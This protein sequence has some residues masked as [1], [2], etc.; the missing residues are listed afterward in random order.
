[1]KH[2]LEMW[3]QEPA[4]SGKCHM[5]AQ[6]ARRR[7]KIH[8]WGAT[9][10]MAL[11]P[12]LSRQWI[13]RLRDTGCSDGTDSFRS[14]TGDLR[15]DVES[16]SDLCENTAWTSHVFPWHAG[17]KPSLAFADSLPAWFS[18]I[19]PVLF[20]EHPMTKAVLVVHTKAG[21]YSSL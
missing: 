7:G 10:Q 14:R 17:A 1:M 16:I 13:N 15:Q 9:P 11:H 19:S 20:T 8:A 3:P 18:H 5:F 2:S 21:V 4:A 12:L 6:R